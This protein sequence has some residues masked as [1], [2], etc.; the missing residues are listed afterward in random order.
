MKNYEKPTITDEV[1]VLEDIIA[2]SNL[3]QANS[4]DGDSSSLEELFPKL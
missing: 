2:V 4:E 3:G 1:I